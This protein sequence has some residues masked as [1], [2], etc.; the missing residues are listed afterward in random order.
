V[1]DDGYLPT[2]DYQFGLRRCLRNVSRTAAERR[3][4]AIERDK[5]LQF[6]KDTVAIISQTRQA[7]PILLPPDICKSS[8]T[9]LTAAG[10][11]RALTRAAGIRSKIRIRYSVAEIFEQYMNTLWQPQNG[12]EVCQKC[13]NQLRR[14]T[15]IIRIIVSKARITTEIKCF[16]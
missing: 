6:L 1:T 12:D 13:S 7:N 9:R 5:T 8:R 16:S 11:G 15:G 14:F 2:P 4:R 3:Y 10:P